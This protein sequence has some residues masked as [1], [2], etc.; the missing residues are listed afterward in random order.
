MHWLRPIIIPIHRSL[1]TR[2]R[3]LNWWVDK[4]C[5]SA[6]YPWGIVLPSV[7]SG[8]TGASSYHLSQAWAAADLGGS[9]AEERVDRENPRSGQGLLSQW[10][11]VLAHISW[12][13]GCLLTAISR[14]YSFKALVGHLWPWK[15][16]RCKT[17]E[18]RNKWDQSW[19]GYHCTQ[20][21]RSRLV[22]LA[23]NSSRLSRLSLSS[24]LSQLLTWQHD[25]T[26]TWTD[27]MTDVRQVLW[28]W[29]WVMLQL[30]WP[31]PKNWPWS[32]G[33]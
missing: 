5:S 28:V 17:N 13:P 14:L 22:Q 6:Y 2:E 26:E 32:I 1:I 33:K 20:E 29:C 21:I 27:G 16:L 25:S 3:L 31:V 8:D 9:E 12:L 7:L 11:W 24:V 15:A 19:L 23:Q 18:I 30:K 4:F 10:S